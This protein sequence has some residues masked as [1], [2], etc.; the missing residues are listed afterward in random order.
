MSDLDWALLRG[1]ED[2]EVEGI[3]AMGRRRRFEHREVIWHDGD[4]AD[5]FHVVRS[6]WIAIQVTTSLGE[7]ATVAVWG[8]GQAAGL[9]DSLAPG[10]YHTTGAIALAPTETLA[11]RSDDM[12]DVR[13]RLP[14]INDAIIELL[15]AKV[16]DVVVQLTDSHYVPADVRVLRRLIVLADL[17]GPGDGEASIPLTQ[18][19]IAEIVGVT[20]P[21][22][23]RVL[24]REQ[25]RGTI[26]LSRRSIVVV[27]RDRLRERAE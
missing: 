6:G 4:R 2:A 18:E 14:S 22:V 24:R 21:T 20:R 8:P 15:A 13:R 11:I 3:L 16:V 25:Q 23:N 5:T 27:D 26:R 9:I 10:K 7:V 1:L 12:G 19:D 17:Y